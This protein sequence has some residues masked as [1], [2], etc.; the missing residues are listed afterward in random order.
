MAKSTRK[1]QSTGN[2]AVPVLA[3]TLKAAVDNFVGA[4]FDV[5]TGNMH[6]GLVL[7]FIGMLRCDACGAF[8]PAEFWHADGCVNCTPEIASTGSDPQP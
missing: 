5:R 1:R 8:V 6:G 2:I 3:D 7:Q 4:G